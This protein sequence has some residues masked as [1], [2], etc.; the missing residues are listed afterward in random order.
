MYQ[1][2]YFLTIECAVQKNFNKYAQVLNYLTREL[3][4]PM[5]N[6]MIK[7]IEKEK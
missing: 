6:N 3:L 2:I 4:S 5:E 1:N 7:E